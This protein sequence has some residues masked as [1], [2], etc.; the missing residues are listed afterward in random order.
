M[1]QNE[2]TPPHNAGAEQAVLGAMMLSLDAV[3]DVTELL[4]PSDYYRP[5]N[6]AIH[7]AIADLYSRG[8]PTDPIAVTTQLL[9]TGDL[10]RA[11]G[12]PYL[13]ECVA[14]VPTVANATWYARQ[15]AEAAGRRHLIE[16]G[17]LTMRLG[18][19]PETDLVSAIDQAG[20]ALLEATT[21]R[22]GGDLEAAADML[23]Q[24]VEGIHEA[25]RNGDAISGLPTGFSD[26]DRLLN[27]LKG[28]QFIVIAGRPGMGKSTVAVDVARNACIRAGRTAA[29]FSLEMGRAELLRRVLSAESK[30]P[31][32]VVNSGRLTEND[33]RRLTQAHARLK[34]VRGLLIDDSPMLTVMDIRARARRI[35]QR[36]SLDLII[37]DYL[38]LMTPSGKK[39]DNRQQEV[40]EISRGLKLLA[41]ELDVPVIAVAQLNRGVEMRQD[42]RP[43]LSDLRESGALE[44]DADI[45]LLVHRDDY[46]DKESSRSGEADFIVAKH[47]GGP[48]DTI[49]VAAQ[50]HLSRF[51]DM[52]VV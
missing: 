44:Q 37:V 15:V 28:G 32:H 19:D 24:V 5:G 42:K 52:S 7:A 34:P 22:E 29:I 14:A 26:L 41:K 23:D 16:A 48:T 51:V 4:R 17:A 33:H 18:S 36:G 3:A 8:E 1:S 27:G 20:A 21:S 45:V 6:G 30:V 38:Q 47:R 10:Q 25:G 50:L 9:A 40:A 13:H 46:Y 35:A 11:G 43:Q 12:A 49:T 2:R 39:A 31:L